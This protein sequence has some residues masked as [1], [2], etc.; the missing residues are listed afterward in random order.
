MDLNP[1]LNPWLFEFEVTNTLRHAASVLRDAI[2]HYMG[3]VSGGEGILVF[4]NDNHELEGEYF[5]T[6]PSA[7]ISLS[8]TLVELD[9]SQMNA[10]E[11]LMGA[12]TYHASLI[13][14]A[15]AGDR[16]GE[17]DGIAR[18]AADI[19]LKLGIKTGLDLLDCGDQLRITTA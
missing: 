4:Y 17:I 9:E 18:L 11:A 8:D 5:R 1:A 14:E 2:P 6:D 15:F 12:I 3:V 7:N 16:D 10:A 13:E 19:E